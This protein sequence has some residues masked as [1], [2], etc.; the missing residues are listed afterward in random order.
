MKPYRLMKFFHRSSLFENSKK[1]LQTDEVVHT[2]KGSRYSNTNLQISLGAKVSIVAIITTT[3]YTKC[4][5]HC[6]ISNK[7]ISRIARV[8]IKLFINLN[9]LKSLMDLFCEMRTLQVVWG[10]Q[11]FYPLYNQQTLSIT[12]TIKPDFGYFL[13]LYRRKLVNKT[14][15]PATSNELYKLFL[16]LTSCKGGD[17]T[18]SCTTSSSCTGGVYSN[19][20]YILSIPLISIHTFDSFK[21]SITS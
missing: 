5:L 19:F 8:T 3:A 2:A 16:T 18:S 13:Y 21:N 12:I 1:D 6:S 7:R 11:G 4:F 9:L 17:C 20:T 10:T 15:P 14:T